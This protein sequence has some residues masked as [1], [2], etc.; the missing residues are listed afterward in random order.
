MK[1]L[2]F[3]IG[4]AEAWG[5]LVGT[6]SVAL[7]GADS[8]LPSTLDQFLRIG[9]DATARAQLIQSEFAAENRRE[10]SLDGVQLLPPIAR[11]AKILCIGRNYES[12]L[13]E[14]GHFGLGPRKQPSVF[15]KATSTVIGPGSP[16]PIPSTSSCL[17]YEVELCVVVGKSARRVRPESA[18][19]YVAGY[20]I[21]NDLALRDL[22]FDADSGG[23]IIAKNFDGSAP[24]G[25]VVT[26]T[27]DI[28][29]PQTLGMRAYVNDE[30]RQEANTKEMIFSVADVI[31]YLSQQLTLDP[32]DM[33]STGTPAGSAFGEASPRWLRAGDRVRLEIDGIGVLENPVAD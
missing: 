8:S 26:L 3:R 28:P 22:Q 20:T 16:I 31:S 18:L 6:S 7:P 14:T 32:G 30:L 9:M 29:D 19:E 5:G 2:S 33:I 4:G 25:P 11:S 1:L 12:H 17:D 27:D 23:T 15:I 24:I 10:L 13:V 21:L